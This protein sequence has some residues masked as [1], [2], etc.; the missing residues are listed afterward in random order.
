MADDSGPNL[1]PVSKWHYAQATL[2]AAVEAVPVIGGPLSVLLGEA[3]PDWKHA[4]LVAFVKQVGAEFERLNERVDA[5]AAQS[6]EFGLMAEEVLRQVTRTSEQD[7]EKLKAFR[8]I[9]LNSCLPG[10]PERYERDYFLGLVSR[11]IEMHIVLVALFRDQE[12]FGRQHSS[13]PEQPNPR[14][15]PLTSNLLSTISGYLTPF[16]FSEDMM[17]AAIRDLDAAGIL[18]GVSETMNTMM[19]VGGARQLSTR[20]TDFGRR[21]AKFIALPAPDDPR[22]GE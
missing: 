7:E 13:G 3:L 6:I 9:L 16:S 5:S 10:S 2:Q 21:F 18:G 1:P 17:R 15:Q 4:Q 12:E 11:L 19:T 20:M 8:A 14:Y 22:T